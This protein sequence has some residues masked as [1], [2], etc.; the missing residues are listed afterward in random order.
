MNDLVNQQIEHFNQI[1]SDYYKARQDPKIS[2][3]KDKIWEN[4]FKTQSC[5]NIS[6]PAKCLEAMCGFGDGYDILKK[7]LKTDFDYSGFDYSEEMV[8][9]AQ[10]R[11]P[12]LHIFI[13]DVLEPV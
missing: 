2:L 9:Y 8:R 12:S 13:Q 10:Q 11:N 7:N 3:L 5:W 1:S 4:A 6:S